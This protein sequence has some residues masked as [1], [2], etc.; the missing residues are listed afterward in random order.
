ML[1]QLAS[2]IARKVLS[3]FLLIRLTNNLDDQ[4]LAKATV[5]SH[6]NAR[7]VI[8]KRETCLYGIANDSHDESTL[9][10]RVHIRL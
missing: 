7:N 6:E 5:A 8:S 10:R 3:C 9:I 4:S 1:H 2:L